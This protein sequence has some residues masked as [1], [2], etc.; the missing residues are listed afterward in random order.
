MNQECSEGVELDV[1]SNR[2]KFLKSTGVAS[3]VAVTSGAVSGKVDK[4]VNLQ[5]D[6]LSDP[7]VSRIAQSDNSGLY[8]VGSGDKPSLVKIYEGSGRA[9]YVDLDETEESAMKLSQK[10]MDAMDPRE[11]TSLNTLAAGKLATAEGPDEILS[12]VAPNDEIP[13]VV[14]RS[15]PVDRELENCSQD[16]CNARSYTHR[17]TGFSFE[18]TETADALG[19]NGLIEVASALAGRYIISS[20]AA[21][22]GIGVIAAT[23]LSVTTGKKYTI[24]YHDNDKGWIFT[25][26]A[27][28]AGFD[29]SYNAKPGDIDEV[30]DNEGEHLKYANQHP[31]CRDNIIG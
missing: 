29:N 17:Q 6:N 13:V 19:K 30:R 26:P 4:R 11:E 14:E 21:G 23:I 24:S 18:L 1:N 27:V 5:K 7:P 22:F 15:D 3:G 10:E 2:R 9:E 31:N 25:Q 8:S 12:A 28:E 16:Y 20:L